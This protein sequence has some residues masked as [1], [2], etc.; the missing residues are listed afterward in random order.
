MVEGGAG[1]I[2]RNSSIMPGC[3]ETHSVINSRMVTFSSVSC[4]SGSGLIKEARVFICGYSG[5]TREDRCL[6]M[7]L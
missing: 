4:E 3:D 2:M 6:I 7:A 1:C 5:L